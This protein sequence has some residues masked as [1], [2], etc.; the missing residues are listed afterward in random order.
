MP[1]KVF[2]CIICGKPTVAS[3]RLCKNTAC[4]DKRLKERMHVIPTP[5]PPPESGV[6]MSLTRC[7]HGRMLNNPCPKCETEWEQALKEQSQGKLA[8]E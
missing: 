3:N 8:D 5:I 2:K 4:Y 7:T 1:Q 6:T